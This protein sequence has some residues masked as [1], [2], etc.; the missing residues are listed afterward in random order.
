MHPLETRSTSGF[1][2]VLR[3]KNRPRVL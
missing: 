2:G 3:P 1:R